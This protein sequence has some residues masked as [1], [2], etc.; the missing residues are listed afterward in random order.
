MADPGS[1]SRGYPLVMFGR[2]VH[3]L[4]RSA[5][6]DRALALAFLVIGQLEVWVTARPKLVSA[7]VVVVTT[8]AL[9][10]RRRAPLA[11]V[12]VTAGGFVAHVLSTSEPP[13]GL[14][15]APNSFA[16]GLTWL[17]VVYSVAAYASLMRAVI[18]LA[19]TGIASIVASLT[20]APR[21][22][23][24]V[25]AFLFSAV[26]P[27][28][29]GALIARHRRATQLR[30]L[31]DDLAL[32]RDQ[33][34]LEA[35]LEERA[36]IARELH[37]V[38]AHGV[39]MMVV[40][41]EAGESL[42]SQEPG[43]A[44]ESLQS[45]QR[46]GRQALVELRR[47]LGIIRTDQSPATRSPQ[48]GLL[49]IESFVTEVRRSGLDVE[50]Q[51][52]GETRPLPQ[53]LELSA[54]RILQEALTNVLKHAGGSRA[55]VRIRYEPSHIELE[56]LD[57]GVGTSDGYGGHG[58][59]GMRERAILY[60]GELQTGPRPGGGYAVRARLPIG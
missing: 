27:W 23:D 26:V 58:L 20:D 44:Q 9:A 22:E 7:L 13:P 15:D 35:V 3:A 33:R 53:G 46:V 2:I 36:R 51:Y 50:L 5:E 16:Y 4:R 55:F 47:L 48:P 40:Q 37:D 42:L 31:A 32:E 24:A 21:F 38:V 45:I 60:G 11:T 41:A 56:V 39:T 14:G 6:A 1:R 34:S 49:D 25:L 10:W 28:L 8:G 43:R 12:I 54:F 29:L 57:D 30:Q 19:A 52:E 18:G 17:I 59:V